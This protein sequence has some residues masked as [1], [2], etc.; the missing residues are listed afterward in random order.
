MDDTAPNAN[1]YGVIR[2]APEEVNPSFEQP[3]VIYSQDPFE[4]ARQEAEY[5]RQNWRYQEQ[6]RRDFV[7]KYMQN[8]E[9]DGTGIHLHEDL[10]VEEAGRIRQPSQRPTGSGGQ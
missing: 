1:T 5:Q 8:A 7:K 2:E 10:S 4:Q 9:A 3:D 6:L